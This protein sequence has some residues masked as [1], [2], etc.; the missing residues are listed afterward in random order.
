MKSNLVSLISRIKESANELIVS[1]LKLAGY[2]N[3][4]PSHG[5]ILFLLYNSENITMREIADKIHRTKATT[6]VLIDKLEKLG[7]VKRLKSATDSRCTF[8]EL[9]E[10]G[11]KFK[12]IFEKISQ[13]LNK[14]VYANIPLEQ[15]E[16]LED[17]LEQVR[18]NLE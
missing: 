14:K 3:I 7:L 18:K 16:L 10:N 1:E 17:L 6:T 15:A 11:K 9:T 2:E 12:P 5:D 13:D 8:V 4:A